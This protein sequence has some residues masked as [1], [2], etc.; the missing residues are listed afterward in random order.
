LATACDDGLFAAFAGALA[1]EDFAG[2]AMV[3]TRRGEAVD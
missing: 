1:F 2:L 3:G